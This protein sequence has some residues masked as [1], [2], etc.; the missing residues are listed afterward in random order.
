MK[1]KL[2]EDINRGHE[3]VSSI[4]I[5][6]EEIGVR[7]YLGKDGNKIGGLFIETGKLLKQ[8]WNEDN[9]YYDDI[10]YYL[11]QLEDKMNVPELDYNNNKYNFAFKKSFITNENKEIINNLNYY[12]N[13]V[14]YEIIEEQV[15]NS[16]IEYEDD[17]Q[18]AYK[19]TESFSNEE[20][21]TVLKVIRRFLNNTNSRSFLPMW[22][23]RK[24]LIGNEQS[25]VNKL[26][27]GDIHYILKNNAHDIKL[28]FVKQ[29]LSVRK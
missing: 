8:L 29:N 10:N 14:G 28:R 18:F 24:S 20:I 2:I 25:I 22:Q 21:D 11:S 9:E 17:V 1:F 13:Q 15:N 3:D 27:D 4:S 26:S 5:L 6:N 23:I 12:L 19:L 16:N 7:L